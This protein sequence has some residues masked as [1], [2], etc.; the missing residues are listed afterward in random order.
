[1]KPANTS[2]TSAKHETVKRT[3]ETAI[4]SLSTFPIPFGIIEQELDTLKGVVGVSLNLLAN[5]IRVNYDPTQI[6]SD[7]LHSFIKSV[8][9]EINRR[10]SIQR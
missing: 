7:E 4:F 6:T 8:V 10:T 3:E 1:M 2:V 5:T 9:S